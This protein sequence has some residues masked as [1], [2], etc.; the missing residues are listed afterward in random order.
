MPYGAAE[1]AGAHGGSLRVYVTG[2]VLAVLLTLLAFGLVMG[3]ELSPASTLAVIFIAAVAQ[4]I[5]HLRFFLHLDTSSAQRWNLAA[6]A[7]T[8]L[9]VTIVI[10]GSVWIMLSLHGRT[11]IPGMIE[12]SRLTVPQLSLG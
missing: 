2:F 1:Q 10:A 12:M 3:K 8:L 9:I 11:M 4:I 5:V 6:F 7:L